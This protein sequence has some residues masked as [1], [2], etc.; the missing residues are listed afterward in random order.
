[1]EGIEEDDAI[2]KKNAYISKLSPRQKKAMVE[3]DGEKKQA[4]ELD[5]AEVKKVV[6]RHNDPKDPFRLTYDAAQVISTSRE[7]YLN[8]D[9]GEGKRLAQD[10]MM[11]ENGTAIEGATQFER[12]VSNLSEFLVNPGN[13][14][15]GRKYVVCCVYIISFSPLNLSFI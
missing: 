4:Y 7:F 12:M 10:P 14:K 1:M 9:G 13:G 3:V 8:I 6:A 2:K 5:N 11:Y 15:F